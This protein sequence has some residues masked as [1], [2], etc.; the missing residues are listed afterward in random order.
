MASRGGVLPQAEINGHVAAQYLIALHGG[1]IHTRDFSS[2]RRQRGSTY[3]VNPVLP[4]PIPVQITSVIEGR[5]W[6]PLIDFRDIGKLQRVLQA[7]AAILICTCTGMRG[8]ECTKLKRGALRTIPR[9]D[10]AFSYRIDGSI[11]KA[12][13]DDND[14]QDRG[15]KQWVWATIKP[16]ADAITALEHLAEVTGSTGCW[17]T[18]IHTISQA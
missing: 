2:W 17:P 5:P 15:G 10:G 16:G 8:E 12:V 9:P 7:A 1:T 3:S 13:R 11:F 18:R 6:L 14:Q 4:Q